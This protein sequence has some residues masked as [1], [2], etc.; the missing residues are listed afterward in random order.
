MKKTT[1]S[2]NKSQNQV[3]MDDDLKARI[4]KYQE[5]LEKTTSGLE[6]SFS[7]ATRSLIEK[8]LKAVE[9]AEYRARRK[10]QVR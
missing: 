4:R 9:R 7:S 5:K 6:V 1:H 2:S 3:R 10:E 8:G